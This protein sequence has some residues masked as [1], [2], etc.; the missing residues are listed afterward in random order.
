M[1]LARD[2]LCLQYI[3]CRRPTRPRRL[4]YLAVART[5]YAAPLFAVLRYGYGAFSFRVVAVI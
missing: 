5:V 2:I 3:S 1:T 4:V